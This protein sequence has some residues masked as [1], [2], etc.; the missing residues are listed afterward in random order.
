MT[1]AALS[2]AILLATACAAAGVTAPAGGSWSLTS[3]FIVHRHGARLPMPMA[4]ATAICG[5]QCGQLTAQGV[6]MLRSLGDTVRRDYDEHFAFESPTVNARGTRYDPDRILSRSDQVDRTIQSA[7][8]FLKALLRDPKANASAPVPIP[9]VMMVGLTHATEILQMVGWTGYFIHKSIV[10]PRDAKRLD[11]LAEK[12]FTATE[13]AAIAAEA[14]QQA[15]CVGKPGACVLTAQDILA[16]AVAEHGEA[17][18]AVAYPALTVS[19]PKMLAVLVAHYTMSGYNSTL[20]EWAA[21]NKMIGSGGFYLAQDLTAIADTAAKSFSATGVAAPGKQMFKEYS[22]HDV[23][24]MPFAQTLGNYS[25]NSPPFAAALIVEQWAARRGGKDEFL[26]RARYGAPDQQ[27]GGHAY[28]LPPFALTCAAANGTAYRA[29]AAG[30][31]YADWRRYLA[32]RGP[33]S[34]L[35][36]CYVGQDDLEATD[37]VPGNAKDRAGTPPADPSYCHL[38]RSMCPLQACRAP[39][40]STAFAI[41]STLVCS[42]L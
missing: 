37:C 32:T 40:A 13:L 8:A 4:N 1:V 24:V 17:A 6:D 25:I 35:G 14:L 18:A 2:V 21:F 11:A 42:K 19:A 39:N 41:T 34:P 26:V 20:P 33:A 28:A 36:T 12:L 5:D 30:C 31:P 29:A 38:Y 10:K 23:T 3:L 15:A 16:S 22:G 7:E 27:P 9:V